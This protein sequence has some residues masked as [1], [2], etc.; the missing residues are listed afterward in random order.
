MA[1]GVEIIGLVL[2]TLPLMISA[3]EHSA[4]GWKT[5][6]HFRK[7]KREIKSILRDLETNNAILRNSTEKLLHH[8]VDFDEMARLMNDQTGALWE[9]NEIKEVMKSKLGNSY[10]AYVGMVAE[11]DAAVNGIKKRL[12]IESDGIVSLFPGSA[13]H[14][15]R[16]DLKAHLSDH[17][18]SLSVR[19]S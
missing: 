13:V 15:L 2:A 7:Y 11:V 14:R 8:M 12:G 6:D 5:L 18:L 1:T 3:L 19:S 17:E 10:Q 16:P 4:D 9:Q